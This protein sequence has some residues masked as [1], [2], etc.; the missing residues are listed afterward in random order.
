MN[1]YQ[2][3]KAIFGGKRQ[4]ENLEIDQELY[5]V[6][7][8]WWR[9]WCDFINVEYNTYEKL[10]K[11][12]SAMKKSPEGLQAEANLS[13]NLHPHAVHN[14]GLDSMFITHNFGDTPEVS[15]SEKEVF[16]GAKQL[17]G[18]MYSS[19]DD[20]MNLKSETDDQVYSKPG[21]IINKDLVRLCH[22]LDSNEET[23]ALKQNMQEVSPS[24]LKL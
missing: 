13:R 20:T 14:S 3:Y 24:Q 4:K 19:W 5:V 7:S 17:R 16:N 2:Q 8:A 12:Q 11:N 1:S 15:Y 9:K 6:P 10:M 23:V 22:S 21:K 18:S